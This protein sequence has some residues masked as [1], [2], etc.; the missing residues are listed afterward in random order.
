MFVAIERETKLILAF[1]LWRRDRTSTED[2]ISKLRDAT[3]S[4]RF[5]ITTDGFQPYINAIDSGLMD[6]VD[7]TQLVRVYAAP[8]EGEAR[9]L[10]AT[11][12]HRSHPYTDHRQPRSGPHLHVA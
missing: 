10:R 8:R 1:H 12:P 5:Q 2:F 4:E 7:F 6:R 3:S 9:A 11:R